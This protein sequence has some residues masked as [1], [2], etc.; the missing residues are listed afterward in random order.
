M[1]L[2][3]DKYRL[4]LNRKIG[5]R[6]CDDKKN[7]RIANAIFVFGGAAILT[8]QPLTDFPPYPRWSVRRA[9]ALLCSGCLTAWPFVRTPT[10]S[11]D[12]PV[13]KR[14]IKF[15]AIALKMAPQVRQVK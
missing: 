6:K 9:P 14:R 8:G 11:P 10:L 15:H 2:L 13:R 4:P 3:V 7:S 1:N 5:L 12:A